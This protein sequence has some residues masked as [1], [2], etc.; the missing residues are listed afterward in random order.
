MEVNEALYSRQL[1]VLGHEAQRR[2]AT[3]SALI[4]GLNGLGAEVAKN[5]VLVSLSHAVKTRGAHP[6]LGRA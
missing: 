6:V 4:V 2:L 3:S 1:Y 5:V